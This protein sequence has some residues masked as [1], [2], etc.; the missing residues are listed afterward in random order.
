MSRTSDVVIIGSGIGGTVLARTLRR[1]GRSVL[2]VERDKH[3][4]F[5][6]GES[7]T[8]LAGLS[9]DRLSRKYRLPNLAQLSTYGR[10][11]RHHPG[12]LRGLKRGFTFYDHRRGDPRTVDRASLQVAASPNESVADSHWLRSAIDH[13]QVR[14]ARAEGVDYL[15]L[16]QVTALSIGDDGADLTLET[17]TS[18]EISVRARVVV[19]GSGGSAVVA[20]LLDLPEATPLETRSSL[21]YGHF[22]DVA[23]LTPEGLDR[24]AKPYPAQWAA[25]H[26]LLAEGWMYELRF[27]SGLVSAGILLREPPEGDPETVWAS[28][29]ERYPALAEAYADARPEVPLQAVPDIQ[30][31]L[32]ASHGPRWVALP[33]TYG[34]VDPLFST[35]LA[36]TLRGVE[37]LSELLGDSDNDEAVADGSAFRRYGVLLRREVN[38]LDNLIAGAYEALDRGFEYF[39]AYSMTYFAAVTWAETRERLITPQAVA[40]EGFLGADDS[41]LGRL[42]DNARAQLPEA[43]KAPEPDESDAYWQWIGRHTAGRDLAGLDTWGPTLTVPVDSDALVE[44]GPLLGLDEE[45]IRTLLPRLRGEVD[46]S[47]ES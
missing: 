40:W 11:L 18:G 17:E 29:I 26:H 31:R 10:W 13:Y 46:T 39:A 27:D 44:R 12:L 16:C 45:A 35:G 1:Q 8:P 28:V 36:W 32:S 6:L 30:H 19:D 42:V 22:H 3:P 47:P 21:I 41:I 34:F 25:V 20:K 23:P 38:Q 43:S 37:R 9:L 5:A 14:Q 7:S 15:D 4:R 2:L 24:S 33:H